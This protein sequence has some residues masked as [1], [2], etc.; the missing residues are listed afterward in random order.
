MLDDRAPG[1]TIEPDQVLW[2]DFESRSPVP[3]AAGTDRYARHAHAILLAWA[4]GDGPVHIEAVADF[5]RGPLRW[6]DL[7]YNFQKF[8]ARVEAGVAVLCAHN[9]GFDR[10]IWAYATDGFPP[11]TPQMWIDS[12]AQATASG[13]P[14]QLEWAAKF[15]G[16]DVLN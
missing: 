15:T 12:R 9:A 8:F 13:L 3:I 6:Y 10:A 7:N 11:T 2:V 1:V 16:T 4:I 5:N 14:A